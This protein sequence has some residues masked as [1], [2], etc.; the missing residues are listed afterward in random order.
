MIEAVLL[1]ELGW[2]DELIKAV[3]R[4]AEPLRHTPTSR[5]AIPTT[6]AQSLSCTAMYSEA[7]IANTAGEI[8]VPEQI[9]KQE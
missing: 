1:R 6:I 5:I 8:S 3:T 7:V 9:E 4:A 2:S